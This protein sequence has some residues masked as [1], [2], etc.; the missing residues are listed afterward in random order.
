MLI[1]RRSLLA[2]AAFLIG[3]DQTGQGGAAAGDMALGQTD[4]PATLIEYA[5]VTC[6]ACAAFHAEVWD[7]LK[8][9]YIDTGKVHFILREYPAPAQVAPVAVAGFQLARCGGASEEQYFERVGVLFA[10]QRDIFAAGSNAGIRDKFVEIGAS[11]GLS[12]DEVISCISDP[13]GAE[14]IRASVEAG[15]RAF[16]ISGTPTLILNGQ[17]LE[18][19]SAHTYEGL[20]RAID[21]AIAGA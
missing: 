9:N 1:G 19:P 13:A 2:G 4:A 5:S 20:A 14:R 3:C 12:R 8:A 17:K 18:D 10:Q 6:S 11:A 16:N 7:G 21:A 15:N